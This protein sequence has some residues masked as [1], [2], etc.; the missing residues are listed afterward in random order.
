MNEQ[1]RANLTG[2]LNRVDTYREPEGSGVAERFIR[3]LKE[4]VLWVHT[5]DAVEDLRRALVEF[6]RHDNETW[7]VARHGRRTPAQ[8]RA[9]RLGVDETLMAELPLAA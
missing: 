8:V 2:C 9:D 5:F 3:T 6:A 1:S 7:L 4:K